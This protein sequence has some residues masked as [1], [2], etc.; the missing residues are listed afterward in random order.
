MHPDS[1]QDILA[2]HVREDV[3]HHVPITLGNA[4]FLK[5]LGNGD[6]RVARVLQVK[7]DHDAPPQA[8]EMWV[9]E[10]SCVSHPSYPGTDARRAPVLGAIG[11]RIG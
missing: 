10:Y 9:T 1:Q 7:L 4:Q 6:A 8:M 5:G 3:T 2:L 11:G